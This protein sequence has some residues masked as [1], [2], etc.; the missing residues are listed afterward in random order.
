MWLEGRQA[1][2]LLSP[3]LFFPSLPTPAPF[4]RHQE[5]GCLGMNMG[6]PQPWTKRKRKIKKGMGEGLCVVDRITALRHV[7]TLIPEPVNT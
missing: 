1:A 3:G 6:G 2:L 7:H 4:L 5:Q